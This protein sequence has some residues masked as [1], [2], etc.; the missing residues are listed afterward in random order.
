MGAGRTSGGGA[1]QAS[2]RRRG[3]RL[4][5]RARD[6]AGARA[7]A[8]AVRGVSFA[9]SSAPRL[10]GP[11]VAAGRCGRWETDSSGPWE[12]LTGLEEWSG[13]IK[14]PT[15]LSKKSKN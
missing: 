8:S 10:I 4:G 5:M 9:C 14:A 6:H 12:P 1:A 3:D 11:L 15:F 13:V 7:S 2:G